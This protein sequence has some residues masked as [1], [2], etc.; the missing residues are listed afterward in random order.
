[1]FQTLNV[2]QTGAVFEMVKPESKDQKEKE[3]T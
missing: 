3:I 1:M 2:A